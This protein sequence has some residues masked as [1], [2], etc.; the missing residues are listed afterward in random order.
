MK[1]KMFFTAAAMIVLT[2]T[3]CNKS[4][5]T[6]GPAAPAASG[7]AGGIFTTPVKLNF[8]SAG[9]PGSVSSLMYENWMDIVTE[10]SNGMVSF[11]YHHSGA[12]GSDVELVQQVIDGTIEGCIGGIATYT[13]YSTLLEA[14]QLPFLITNYDLEW[15]V[16]QSPEFRALIEG[17]EAAIGGVYMRGVV[18]SGMR[19]FGM[20]KG[21]VN[22]VA[23]IR[24]KKIRTAQSELLLK[25]FT[26]LGANPVSLGYSE[27]YPALQNGVVD[28][29]DVNFQTA[30]IQ[31]HHEVVKYMSTIGMYPYPS[32]ICFNKA[33]MDNLPVGYWKFMEDCLNEASETFFTDTIVNSD[34]ELAA[35]LEAKGV[36][37]NAI[38]DTTPWETLTRPLYDEYTSKADPR[39]IRFVQAVQEMKK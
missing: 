39:V 32:F 34:A 2:M 16:L 7:A 4:G 10:R 28:G 30:F 22:T 38:T 15:K 13:N 35:T 12:L 29:E 33:K 8:G 3:A 36:T 11:N 26:L 6:T 27:V 23:D 5:G 24:G 20:I 25:A 18:D 9:Y 31:N 1:K 17:T 37:I 21:P 14:F 19:H